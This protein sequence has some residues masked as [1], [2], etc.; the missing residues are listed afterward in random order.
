MRDIGKQNQAVK[1]FTT[2]QKTVIFF[3]KGLASFL[4]KCH[5]Y[6]YGEVYTK[7][8]RFSKSDT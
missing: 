7:S 3:K 2:N 4:K 6:P 8:E 1:Y 5:N